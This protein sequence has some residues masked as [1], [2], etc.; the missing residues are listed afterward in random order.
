MINISNLLW[1]SKKVCLFFFQSNTIYNVHSPFVYKLLKECLENQKNYYAYEKIESLRKKLKRSD[2]AIN[3]S[4]FGA[5]A[6]NTGLQKTQSIKYLAST[7]S[8]NFQKGSFLFKLVK[9]L[10]PQSILELGSCIG[11][12]S[13]YMASARKKARFISVE[14]CPETYKLA[15][16]N[17]QQLGLGHLDFHCSTFSDF[18]E[19]KSIEHNSLDL[20]Y[21]DG[22]HQY[23]PSLDYFE[24]IYPLLNKDK[25]VVVMDDIYWSKGM[26]Q[27]WKKLK[28]DPRV[29]SSIDLFQLGLLIL[30]T[31]IKSKQH[32]KIIRHK[33][34]P[35]L[36]GF[37][38]RKN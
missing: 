28:E 15:K 30:N 8:S 24:R 16:N 1:R 29:H 32:Y 26:N 36:N 34:K 14:A 35:W 18:F 3:K 22:H 20:V 4:D 13:A 19:K 6:V 33:Y 5:G 25:A 17:C 27:A 10:E 38:S 37:F 7:A 2:K 9:Y 31:D 21:M 23:Q 12:G 11:I